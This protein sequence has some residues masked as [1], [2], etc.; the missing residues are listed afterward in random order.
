MDDKKINPILLDNTDLKKAVDLLENN[1][2]YVVHA[3]T[4]IYNKKY[5]GALSIRAYPKRITEIS[6]YPDRPVKI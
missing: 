1:G 3:D 5:N 2:F 4:G 6:C